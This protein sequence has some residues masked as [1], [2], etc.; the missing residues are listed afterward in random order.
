MWLFVS[1]LFV[2]L[3]KTWLFIV[4][5][6]SSSNSLGAGENGQPFPAAAPLE[7]TANKGRFYHGTLSEDSPAVSVPSGVCPLQYVFFFI[8]LLYQKIALQ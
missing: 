1:T 3:I 4:L 6:H 8:H 2:W 7:R 5:E